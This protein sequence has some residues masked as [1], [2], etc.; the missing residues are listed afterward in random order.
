MVTEEIAFPVGVPSP[1]EVRLG[2]AAFTVTGRTALFFALA[3]PF[4]PLLCGSTYWG[5]VTGKSQM[6][7]KDQTIADGMVEEQMLIKTE[8]EKKRMLRF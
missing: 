1:V 5:T 7:G 2:I 3:D 4:F 6:F 8:N